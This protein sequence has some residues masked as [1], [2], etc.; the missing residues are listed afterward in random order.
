[1]RRACCFESV[2]T[3]LTCSSALLDGAPELQPIM[4]STRLSHHLSP[5]P[6]PYYWGLKKSP[7]SLTLS[8]PLLENHHGYLLHSLMNSVPSVHSTQPTPSFRAALK[9]KT[10]VDR[11]SR[12]FDTKDW[13]GV[14]KGAQA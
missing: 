6:N 4:S 13:P 9:P 1:M 3:F 10:A 5:P 7:F 8:C 11:C 14:G 2:E 12:N